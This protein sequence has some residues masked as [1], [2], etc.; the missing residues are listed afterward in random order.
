MNFDGAPLFAEPTVVPYLFSI[1]SP[2]CSVTVPLAHLHRLLEYLN[3]P[4]PLI[5]SAWLVAGL[6]TDDH[7]RPIAVAVAAALLLVA[8]T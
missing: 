5:F 7:F 2:V 8:L 3:E 1:L 4:G 6:R